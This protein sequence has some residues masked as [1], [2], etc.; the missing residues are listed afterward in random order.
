MRA[1]GVLLLGMLFGVA[2][3]AIADTCDDLV[4]GLRKEA[5]KCMTKKKYETRLACV[6]VAGDA[7][8][9]SEDD[10]KQCQTA[11]KTLAGE[12]A[13]DEGQSYPDQKLA[14]VDGTNFAGLIPGVTIGGAPVADARAAKTSE[15]V[16]SYDREPASDCGALISELSKQSDSCLDI[17]LESAREACGTKAI[18]YAHTHGYS[19]CQRQIDSL[20]E[21][22]IQKEKSK[23]QNSVL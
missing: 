7:L 20:R 21:Q 16:R 1:V 13:A 17:P 9:F 11:T 18:D 5:N 3:F 12:L 19:R 2:L 22:V 14:F 15:Q 4:M 10:W 8:P 23:Y 6:K